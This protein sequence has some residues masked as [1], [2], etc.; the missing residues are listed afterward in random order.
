NTLAY[1]GQA[2]TRTQALADSLVTSA[3][4]LIGRDKAPV[5]DQLGHLP[6]SPL[7]A[8][9]GPLLALLGKGPEGKSGADGLSLQA[10]LTRVTRVRL[11]LQQVSTA[12]DPLEMTQALAQTVFQGKSIDL[13]DTQSYGSLMAASLG[14]EWGGAAQTLFVQPLEHAWQRV[15][16]PSAAGINSQWQRSIVSHWDDAFASRYPFTATASDASLPMLG[17]MIRADSG[18]IEQFLQRQLSGVLRKEG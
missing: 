1:Q 15:L 12:A 10:F 5:I 18:R 3:Q 2:G 14:A 6:S 8:T 11:K 7:D 17:Q 4:K 9:F 13:T 16:Q